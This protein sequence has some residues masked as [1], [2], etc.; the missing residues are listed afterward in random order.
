MFNPN[1]NPNQP[2]WLTHFALPARS[3]VIRA[4]ACTLLTACTSGNLA[5]AG[6]ILVNPGFEADGNHGS[7]SPVTGWHPVPSG[8][9]YINTDSYAHSGNNYYK[10]WG[11][12]NG[13]PNYQANYQDLSALPTSTYKADGWMFTVVDDSLWK[14]D[15]ANYAWLEVSFRDAADNI[16]A[17]YK[18]DLFSDNPAVTY[19][20]F[21]YTTNVWFDL[22][23]T[24]ICQPTPPYAVIGSTNTLVAP[25]GTVKVRFQHTL[26]QLYYGGGSV[27][28]DDA[29]LNQTGGPVPPQITQLYPGNLLFAT[30]KI[31]FHVTSAS[32]T[33]IETSNIHLVL[34][35]TDVSSACTFS[36]ATPDISVT[37]SGLTAGTWAYT[38]SITVTDSYSFTASATMNF[39]TVAPAY[40][41]EAEDYDFTNGLYFNNPILSSTE[42][43]NSYYGTTGTF[44]IDFSGNGGGNGGP[45]LYRTNDHVGIGPAGETARPAFLTAQ[46]TDPGVQDYVVGYIRV[47]DWMNYSRNYPAGTYNVYARLAGGAGATVLSLSNIVSGT[48]LGDFQFVGNDWGAYH[49]IPV[50]DADGNVLPFTFDG[51]KQTLRVTL[52]SGGE[53][54]NFFMLIPA[55]IGVPFL[56]NISPTNGALF[57]TDTNFSFTADSSAGINSNSIHLTLNGADVTSGL[58]IS[59]SA[60][61]KTVSW[62]FLTSNTMYT[63]VIAVTNAAGAGTT[64]TVQFDTMSLSNFYVKATDFDYSSGQW[65]TAGNGL[66]ADAYYQNLNAV[67]NVDYS[68]DGSSG[69]FPF[70]RPG[71][72]TETT[73]DAPLSGYYLGG[74]YDVGNFNSGDWGN[75]TR[76]YP[77]GKYVV[78]GRLAGYSLTAYLDEVT[79]GLG[80]QNQTTR[81]LGTW[82]ADPEGWQSWAWVPLTDAGLAAPKIIT[83]GGTNTLR[84]TSGGS[85]NANYFML[86]P[87]QGINIKAVRSGKNVVISFLTQVAAVY[88]V[89]YSPSLSSVNWQLL[90]TVSGDGT[91]KSVSDPVATGPRYYKVSSP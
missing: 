33:P 89:Y 37:Y 71:L 10:V 8:F 64:R 41:W 91:V 12:F 77:A 28:F 88:H 35:G 72:A 76:N 34:N 63:A 67:S 39:D 5:L 42:K 17:L 75:Y 38:A 84:I 90:A 21:A 1:M 4:L 25:P 51:S 16:L 53:N 70:R 36:G 74:D 81:R 46:L 48:L 85:V 56:S 61:T 22:P 59:G 80:T 11:A 54:M 26:Y 32:S 57:V 62:P 65:D 2:G 19:S 66:V 82:K 27:Y 44:G 52:M 7:G 78:Y 6:N 31:S 83:L 79:G 86:V 69:N 73:S 29:T 47:N 50:T 68:H 23:V 30:N 43:A 15:D 24:N 55:Q 45:D 58:S 9:W 60:N 18:S 3:R 13:A 40:V 49:Y 20:G 87:V 14:S